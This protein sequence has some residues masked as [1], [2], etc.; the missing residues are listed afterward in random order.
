MTA[1]PAL[2]AQ[3]PALAPTTATSRR[4]LDLYLAAGGGALI[5]AGAVVWGVAYARFQS[6]QTACN[7]G[8]GCPD[9]ADRVSTINALEDVAIGTWIVGGAVVV[10]SGLHYEL[11]K[12]PAPV[13]VAIDP[14][15]GQVAVRGTF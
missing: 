2:V 1:S 9:Y 11:R 13:Q 4:P 14:W 12:P 10:V 7:Q 3:S 6:A 15:N 8:S 5:I